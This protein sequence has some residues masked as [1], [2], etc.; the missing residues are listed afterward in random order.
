MMK[1]LFDIKKVSVTHDVFHGKPNDL[2]FAL[3]NKENPI[4]YLNFPQQNK[5]K[6]SENK[7]SAIRRKYVFF[8]LEHFIPCL[9][10]FVM[11]A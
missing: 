4:K 6:K 10:Q 2:I 3:E 7:F 5:K 9:F 1:S 11:P 8:Y